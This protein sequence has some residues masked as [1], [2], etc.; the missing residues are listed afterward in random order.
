MSKSGVPEEA[1]VPYKFYLWVS[2]QHP[3]DRILFLDSDECCKSPIFTYLHYIQVLPSIDF[4]RV[5]QK[6]GLLELVPSEVQVGCRKAEPM[7]EFG[8]IQESNGSVDCGSVKQE[9]VHG[10]VDFTFEGTPMRAYRFDWLKGEQ[11]KEALFLVWAGETDNVGCLLFE[12][13]FQWQHSLRGEV[14]MFD[15]RW[16][17]STDLYKTIQTSN[18]EDLVLPDQILESL[19][20]DIDEFFAS[21]KVYKEL[22]AAW[23]RGILLVGPPGNGKTFVLRTILK[24]HSD[25]PALYVKSFQTGRFST[26]ERGI[27]A[28]FQKTRSCAPCILVMEDLDSLV[29]EETRSFLLNE[30]DGLESN[31]GI[32]IIATSNHPDKLD[33]AFTKRPSRFDTK[34]HLDNPTPLERRKFINF[35]L[36]EKFKGL[37]AVSEEVLKEYG[38]IEKLVE[39]TEGWS[40]A[41]LKELFVSFAV[42]SASNKETN[43][44]V[45]PV[46]R[47]MSIFEQLQGHVNVSKTDSESEVVKKSKQLS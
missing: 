21:R 6:E 12:R 19:N 25:K 17:K 23:K 34:Y 15:E 5:P 44:N 20:R 45:S 1:S 47:L 9:L 27:R 14:W 43:L 24:R 26:P 33:N 7:S 28:I 40:F 39:G 16:Q 29:S 11:G 42:L 22:G 10:S 31:D 2:Q 18:P 35:W 36:N 38:L 37:K 3:Q 8:E 32:I 41:F 30:I 4:A 46:T 13:M